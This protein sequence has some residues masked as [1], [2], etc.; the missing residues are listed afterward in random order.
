[1]DVCRA[2]EVTETQLSAMKSNESTYLSNDDINV[3][4]NS[5]KKPSGN[6]PGRTGGNAAPEC[7]YCGRQHNRG[8]NYCRASG[9][10]CA[11]CGKINHFAAKCLSSRKTSINALQVHESDVS[12]DD[13]IDMV[14][15]REEEGDIMHVTQGRDTRKMFATMTFG[16][17][18]VKMLVDSGASSMSLQRQQ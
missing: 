7:Q 5:R 1:M 14:S 17:K 11:K 15:L 2:A 9:K 16:R 10:L 18:P 12:D 13:V 8:R 3:V 6:E 4:A